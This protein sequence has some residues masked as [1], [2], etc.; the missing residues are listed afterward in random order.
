ME[1]YDVG[2]HC[3]L[4]ECN[5]LDY[6][7]F[8][9]KYCNKSYCLEH[10]DCK[11]HLNCSGPKDN[12]VVSCPV[13]NQPVNGTSSTRS[14]EREINRLVE[15]HISAGCPPPEFEQ[16]LKKINKKCMMKRC[17][18]AELVPFDCNGC[19]GRF[20]I[21]HRM[22][23]SHEC[24]ALQSSPIRNGG[25]SSRPSS[26]PS[27]PKPGPSTKGKTPQATAAMS[28]TQN[29]SLQGSSSGSWS[30]FLSGWR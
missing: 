27:S 24:V 3:A 18:K 16:Q 22:N 8:A 28:R 29:K 12:V 4:K 23:L 14:S 5:Q 15:E 7:P 6:L 17:N 9:C 25:S 30:S 26:T 20:C 1:I 10:K 2:K 13:C 11:H 21:Q 19:G